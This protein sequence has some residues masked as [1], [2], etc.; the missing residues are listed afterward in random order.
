[1]FWYIVRRIAYAVPVLVGVSLLT[2]LLFY[3]SASP[4]TIARR[5]LPAK[6]P[7]QK[8]IEAWKVQHGYDRPLPVQ[9]R[10]YMT[11]LLL[12]RFGKSDSIS[13]EDIWSRIRQGAPPSLVIASSIF[14]G[15]ILASV[16]LALMLA[17][18]RG[19]YLDYWGTLLCV[20]LLCIVY[21]V[22]IIA[23]QYL[24]GRVLRYFPIQGYSAGV[25][26]WKFILLPSL[27]GIVAGL[28]ATTRL[29][30]TFLLEQ[31]NQDYVRTARAKGVSETAILFKHVL[32]NAAIPI[33]TNSVAIIPS[34]FLGN[35][36][37]ES[38]FSIPGLGSY[39]V[40]AITNQDFA[41]VRA[42]VY[43]GTLMVIMG[44]VLTDITYA[45]VDPRVR[46]E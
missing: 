2:F 42:M 22:Y 3:A 36:L 16:C 23:G 7:T 25:D 28:G 24:L 33:A 20:V 30:R 4:D 31:I 14:V 38:F 18:F 6:N 29:Y 13:G 5:N 34:L 8:Q 43:L 9:F 15:E 37:L 39:L 1:M 46:L 35:L 26:A 41:V 32:K 27:I 21:I 19:T 45:L 40:D 44:Y 17:Y 10:V 11:Q 12:L